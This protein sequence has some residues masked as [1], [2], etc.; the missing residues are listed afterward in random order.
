MYPC[1]SPGLLMT[2]TIATTERGSHSHVHAHTYA[3]TH[4]LSLSHALAPHSKS[5]ACGLENMDVYVYS[6]KSIYVFVYVRMHT[7]VCSRL[8]L[9][10]YI[11]ACVYTH[12]SIYVFAHMYIHTQVCSS[13]GSNIM[14]VDIH[15]HTCMYIHLYMYIYVHSIHTHNDTGLTASFWKGAHREASS[16]PNSCC[17]KLASYDGDGSCR[18]GSK[19]DKKKYHHHA[20]V[21]ARSSVSS[22]K[23][24]V[25]IAHA[26]LELV[27]QVGGVFIRVQHVDHGVRY[28]AFCLTCNWPHLCMCAYSHR[29]KDR[30]T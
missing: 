5:F 19:R 28:S 21:L 30:Q 10:E 13:C 27:L 6:H 8:R 16:E 20:A 22:P 9:G 4:T 15:T 1:R 7:Q 3:H 24:L 25:S 17:Q 18:C 2:K 11:C 12:M 14:C 23:V 26:F 29:R